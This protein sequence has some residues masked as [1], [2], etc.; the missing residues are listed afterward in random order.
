MQ[1][2]QNCNGLG[3]IHSSGIMNGFEIVSI[4]VYVLGGVVAAI[5][6]VI[7]L[8]ICKN[9]F[10]AN[11]SMKKRGY[12]KRSYKKRSYKKRGYKKRGYK[13]RGYQKRGYQ[14][15]TTAVLVCS[16]LCRSGRTTDIESGY[17]GSQYGGSFYNTVGNGGG[18]CNSGGGSG[19]GGGGCDSGGGGCGQSVEPEVS[20]ALYD[21]DISTFRVGP[22]QFSVECYRPLSRQTLPGGVPG[23]DIPG[24]S[25]S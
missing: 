3:C 5:L 4:F 9:K 25:G 6:V 19:S 23:I 16:H 1:Q 13:K 17:G 7:Y 15:R 10:C 2:T 20:S 22:L 21:Y 8:R 12:K 18:D 24:T 14:K 11:S